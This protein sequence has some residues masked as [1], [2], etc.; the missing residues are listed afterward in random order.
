MH[1]HNISMHVYINLHIYVYMCMYIYICIYIITNIYLYIYIYT[2][3]YI[4]IEVGEFTAPDGGQL[5]V[6]GVEALFSM[7]CGAFT[8]KLP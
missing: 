2:C 4:Y 6:P 1:T 8:S 5:L 3:T 7:E